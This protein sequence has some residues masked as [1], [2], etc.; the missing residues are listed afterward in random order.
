[1]ITI[2]RNGKRR[3]SPRGRWLTLVI[4]AA[5]LA[6]LGLSSCQ[7]ALK[8]LIDKGAVTARGVQAINDVNAKAAE[9]YDVRQ[10]RAKWMEALAAYGEGDYERT[11]RM[12]DETYSLLTNLQLVAERIYYK[13]TDGTLVSGLVFRPPEGS[14]PWPLIVVN[15]AGFGTAAD[16]SDVALIFRDH[17]YLVFNP[18]YRGSGNSQGQHEL[19]KGEVDDA[20]SG[21]DYLKSQGLVE[22]GRVGLYGQSHGAAVAMLTSARD[23]DIKAVVEEA[24]FTDAADLYYNVV[25]NPDPNIR[26]LLNDAEFMKAGT[27]DTAPAEYAVRS[28]LNY[29][30]SITAPTLIIH[31]ALDPL[32]PVSQAERM[33]AALKAGGTVVEIKIYPNEAHCVSDP[34]GRVE[35]WE[36]T[37]AWFDK[38]V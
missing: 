36:L 3:S 21:I 34:A 18:D 1:M 29:A 37:L 30:G 27:P 14:G 24:G 9:G 22:N 35:V 12:I 32:I 6:A 31:G 16:F 20:I 38:Y 2:R 19:A 7:C 25:N 13:S 11:N 5:L 17:G 33:Y 23:P 15:H 4:V 8:D 10:A 28:A 26:A